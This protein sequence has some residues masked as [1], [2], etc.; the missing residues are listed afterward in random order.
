VDRR[1]EIVIAKF[2][3]QPIPIDVYQIMLT[4]RAVAQV[5]SYLTDR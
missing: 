4:M 5:V 3:S 1:N 2:S